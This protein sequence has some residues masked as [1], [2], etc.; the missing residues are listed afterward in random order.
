MRSVKT[1]HWSR[2]S[3]SI[4]T[5]AESSE[6]STSHSL[7]CRLVQILLALY[8]IPALLLVFVVGVTGIFIVS[9][10]RLLGRLQGKTTN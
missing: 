3:N 6:P 1:A 9:V 2:Y 10:A 7:A 8:L 5:F 4:S